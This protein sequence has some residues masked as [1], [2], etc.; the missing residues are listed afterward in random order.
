MDHHRQII[1]ELMIV[2]ENAFGLL[3]TI[4]ECLHLELGLKYKFIRCVFQ[5]K[6][7]VTFLIYGSVV[8][9]IALFL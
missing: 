1:I 2:M 7:K 6:V 5:L 4:F 8:T 3:K 9:K